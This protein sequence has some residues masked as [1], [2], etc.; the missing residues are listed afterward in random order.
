MRDGNKAGI[1]YQGTVRN[2]FVQLHQMIQKAGGTDSVWSGEAADAFLL[3]EQ[4][5]YEEAV[6]ILE[7]MTGQDPDTE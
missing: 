2:R 5:L 3:R 1:E 6:L 7:Q 4:E